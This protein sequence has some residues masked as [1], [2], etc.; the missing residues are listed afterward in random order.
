MDAFCTLL[1]RHFV[2]PFQN[3]KHTLECRKSAL[4][5]AESS[6]RSMSSQVTFNFYIMCYMSKYAGRVQEST[7]Y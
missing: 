3:M 4:I 7:L 1:S 2:S 6:L 5:N